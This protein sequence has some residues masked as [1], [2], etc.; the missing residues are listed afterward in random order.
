VVLQL[1]APSL[2]ISQSN[3]LDTITVTS[4]TLDQGNLLTR[5]IPAGGVFQVG[6][7]GDFAI[8]ANQAPALY[9]ANFDL[10]ADYQ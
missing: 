8:A 4:M 5:T 7:G 10:T 2:L 9:S 1:S 3:P 6:V